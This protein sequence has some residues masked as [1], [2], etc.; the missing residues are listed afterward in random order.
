MLIQKMKISN[1][2]KKVYQL[3]KMNDNQ[4]LYLFYVIYIFGKDSFFDKESRKKM[5]AGHQYISLLYQQHI[6][7]D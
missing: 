2:L 4:C 3:E 5:V 7:T 6:N 1:K